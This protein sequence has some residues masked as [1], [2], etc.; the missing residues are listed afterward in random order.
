LFAFDFLILGIEFK[1]L[2]YINNYLMKTILQIISGCLVMLIL[3]S[4]NKVNAVINNPSIV[5]DSTVLLTVKTV[6]Y[7]NNLPV[8]SLQRVIRNAYLNGH[9]QILI[10]ET[11]CT[12]GV[13]DTLFN[14]Y[15]YNNQNQLTTINYFY[16]SPSLNLHHVG[17]YVTHITWNN[18]KVTKIEEDSSGVPILTDNIIYRADG[19]NTDVIVHSIPSYDYTV[20]SSGGQVQ[21]ITSLSGYLTV[22]SQ[23]M[24]V[25][26]IAISDDV[27]PM[28]LGAAAP[29]NQHFVDSTV[30]NFNVNGNYDSDTSFGAEADTNVLN[31]PATIG[32]TTDTAIYTYYRNTSE[33]PYVYNLLDSIYGHDLYTLMCFQKLS[34]LDWGDA[35][36]G[37]YLPYDENK[38]S[39]VYYRQTLASYDYGVYAW[40]NG[41]PANGGPAYVFGSTQAVT[42]TYDGQNRITKSILDQ[43]GYTGGIVTFT[44]P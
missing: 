2:L 26:K 8:D 18:D 1:R 31:P 28:G 14:V 34:Y 6:S 16:S 33:N 5:T 41:S 39:Y 44:Y 23:F 9:K 29:A 19:P 17:G 43:Y 22:N 11:S 37:K 4:C 21:V 40:E 15:V 38:N 24:P 35:L 25:S 42:N 10:Y 3:Y 13:L 30:F 12:P 7:D 27:Y 20:D 32:Y 36:G